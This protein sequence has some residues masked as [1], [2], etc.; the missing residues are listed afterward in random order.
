MSLILCKKIVK[1]RYEVIHM[2]D[3]EYLF[4][5]DNFSGVVILLD[6]NLN[7]VKT[8]GQK[9]SFDRDKMYRSLSLALRKRDIET[10]K[11]EKPNDDKR[12]IA[13]PNRV[14]I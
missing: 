10:E 1:Y 6:K 9:E 12:P 5:D 2:F 4:K 13:R 11:I 7:V 14:P 8:N 3:I